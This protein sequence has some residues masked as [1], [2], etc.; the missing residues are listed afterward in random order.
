MMQLRTECF[1]FRKC[2]SG[3]ISIPVVGARDQ[4]SDACPAEFSAWERTIFSGFGTDQP[5]LV[6]ESN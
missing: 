3:Y 1:R 4:A 5:I 2:I 6:V